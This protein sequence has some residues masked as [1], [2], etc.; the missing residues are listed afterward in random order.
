SFAFLASPD[1]QKLTGWARGIPV[2]SYFLPEYGEAGQ[3][4]IDIANSAI[5]HFETLYGSYPYEGLV[6]AQNAY[7]GGMEYSGLVSMSSYAYETHN[8]SPYSLLTSLTVHEIAHQWWY[9]AVGN[10][11]VHEPWL[12]ESFAKYSE[13]L[14]YEH[15][16]PGITGW[17]W[18]NHVNY[19][20]PSGPLDSTIYDYNDTP[21]YLHNLY[22]Q[23]ALFLSDLRDLMGDEAFFAFVQDY[24]NQYESKM[25]TKSDFLNT[26]RAHTDVDLTPLFQAYFAAP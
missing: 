22:G 3:A 26:A 14:F 1:Y 10:D 24:R 16:Y 15:Y 21:T 8:D 20:D 7:Y 6:V 23:G 17:W 18:E 12:D 4:V 9:G 11:Q 13:V 19:W 25:A 5:T 2:E